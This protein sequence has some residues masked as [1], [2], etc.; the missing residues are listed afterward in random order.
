MFVVLYSQC[1]RVV[2]SSLLSPLSVEQVARRFT[3]PCIEEVRSSNIIVHVQ[4][5]FA[6]LKFTVIARSKQASKHTHAQRNE[7]T[8]VLGSLR[9]APIIIFEMYRIAGKFG[10]GFNLAIWRCRKK[11]PN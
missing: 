8:L 7:V 3:I 6:D 10:G 4:V 9:L 1:P 2:S 11:S 5:K